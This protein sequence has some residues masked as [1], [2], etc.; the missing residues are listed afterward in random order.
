MHNVSEFLF[1]WGG[2]VLPLEHGGVKATF[3]T[4]SFF[5]FCCEMAFLHPFLV[6]GIPKLMVKR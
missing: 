5:L 2:G 3:R 6:L 1:K 4:F